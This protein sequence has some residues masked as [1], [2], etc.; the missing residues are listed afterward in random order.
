MKYL[1]QGAMLLA[2]SAMCFIFGWALF[3]DT[4]QYGS[5]GTVHYEPLGW[6]LLFFGASSFVI[7]VFAWLPKIIAP[8]N[9][10]VPSFP[11]PR[12]EPMHPQQVGLHPQYGRKP[13]GGM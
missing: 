13:P 5:I 12:I 3:S 8:Y 6:V 10:R 1:Y 2:I 7:F 9:V 4:I 11:K